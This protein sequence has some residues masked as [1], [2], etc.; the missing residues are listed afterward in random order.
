MH[1]SLHRDVA[2]EVA[3]L[4]ATYKV[5][6]PFA[7]DTK[8]GPLISSKQL[9]RVLSYIDAGRT[10]GAELQFGGS[11]VG[12]TGY[13]IQPTVFSGVSNEMKIAREEI[14]G[15]VLSIIPFADEADAVLK[16]NDTEYG[17]SA[18]VWTRDIGRG[19]RVAHALK[20]GR[21]WINAYGEADL[22]IP[23]GGYKQSGYGRENGAGIDR[24]LHADEGHSRALL[25]PLTGDLDKPRRE[26]ASGS[27]R[28]ARR[29][30]ATR[31]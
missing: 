2:H 22:V 6:S 27:K 4:A 9:D 14:F 24:R 17:L 25:R 20:A 29:R 26:P 5:G 30:R 19:H 28:Y 8:L 13:F 15:P 18:A 10:E 1:A 23:F 11:R 31:F 21:V 12:S 16:G 7:P 3:K